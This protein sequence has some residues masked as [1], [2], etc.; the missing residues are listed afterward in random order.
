MDWVLRVRPVVVVVA[1]GANDGLRGQSPAA[2][3]TN[4][5][6]IIAPL[7]ASGSRVLL[8]G[9]RMP[10]NYGAEYTREFAGVFPDVARRTRVAM[11][12]FL[13]EG[14]AAD[15]R[16]LQPAGLHPNAAGHQIIADR[17]W[18]HLLPLLQRAR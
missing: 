4:L 1:L 9:M 16:F 14:V 12:P 10:P 3:R 17:L 5:E 13:L 18:P 2:M 6:T 11:M 7:T 15:P 8:A